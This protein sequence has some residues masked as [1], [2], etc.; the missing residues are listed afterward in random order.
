MLVSVAT[1]RLRRPAPVL[2][3][4]RPYEFNPFTTENASYYSEFYDL[5]AGFA[6]EMSNP[7][8][9]E[10]DQDHYIPCQKLCDYLAEAGY[11]G[12]RYPSALNEDG[13]NL[14]LFDPTIAEIQG[15]SLVE[16][17]SVRVEY[18]VRD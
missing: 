14:L 15:S 18:D 5:M 11:V 17:R 13:T 9:R 3:L 2:D 12:V 1:V 16:I 4:T 6:A 7:L 8:Q 10:D